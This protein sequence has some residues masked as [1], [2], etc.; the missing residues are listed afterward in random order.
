MDYIS[1]KF[2]NEFSEHFGAD[3][4]SVDGRIYFQYQSSQNQYIETIIQQSIYVSDPDN[5]NDPLDCWIALKNDIGEE[6]DV[7]VSLSEAQLQLG[8]RALGIVCLTSSWKNQLM[9]SHYADAHSGLCLG[10]K[11][12]DAKWNGGDEFIFRPVQYQV[13]TEVPMSNTW[14]SESK[15]LPTETTATATITTKHPDWHYEREW[16]IMCS[17]PHKAKRV[18]LSQIGLELEIVIFGMNMPDWKVTAICQAITGA[19]IRPTF[20]RARYN[21]ST[22][23]LEK[24]DFDFHG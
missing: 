14:D 8:A 10:F 21:P 20:A 18:N 17:P 15:S 1:D 7:R 12:S 5:F 4:E 2:K 23:E 3:L 22:S 9:W 11:F 19:N 16:R 24:E 6:N 13:Q